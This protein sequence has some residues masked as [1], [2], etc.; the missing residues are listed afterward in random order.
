MNQWVGEWG[1]EVVV[2]GLV[3]GLVVRGLVGVIWRLAMVARRRAEVEVGGDMVAEGAS[4]LSVVGDMLKDRG[5]EVLGCWF[6]V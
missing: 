1:G 6:E 5:L 3:R 2:E 4:A